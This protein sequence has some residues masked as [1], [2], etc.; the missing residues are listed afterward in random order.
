[1]WSKKKGVI[2]NM[3][4]CSSYSFQLLGLTTELLKDENEGN[5]R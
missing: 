2:L 1:M 5:W 4:R 3:V